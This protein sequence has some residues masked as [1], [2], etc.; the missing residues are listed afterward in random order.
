MM[1]GMR[2]M[3]T[4]SVD[5]LDTFHLVKVNFCFPLP[6]ILFKLTGAIP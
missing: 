5:N 2:R 3:Q 4:S 1:T 6:I